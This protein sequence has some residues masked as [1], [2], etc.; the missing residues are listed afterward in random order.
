[1]LNAEGIGPVATGFTAKVGPPDAK[2]GPDWPAF[3]SGIGSSLG[4]TGTWDGLMRML[5]LEVYD[6]CLAWP[7][8]GS[9][10]SL[11]AAAAEA[12]GALEEVGLP[13]V[14]WAAGDLLALGLAADVYCFAAVVGLES[15]FP[16]F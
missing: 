12:G 14:T 4:L 8:C 1:M 15:Y 10:W 3:F 9:I 11:D 13:G 5:L 16:G 7:G 2:D 6:D